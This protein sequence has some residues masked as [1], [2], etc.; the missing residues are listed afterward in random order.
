MSTIL[1]RISLAVVLALTSVQIS[2]IPPS[3]RYRMYFQESLASE[4][5]WFL[6]EMRDNSMRGGIQ[7]PPKGLKEKLK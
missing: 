1:C 3:D 5:E 4:L 7:K 2:Y 6:G